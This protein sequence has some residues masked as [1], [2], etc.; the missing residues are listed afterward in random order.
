M[1]NE[2]TLV[3]LA[4]SINKGWP[5]LYMATVEDRELTV[6]LP[7]KTI[8][9]VY[10]KNGKLNIRYI[11]ERTKS[12]R[13]HHLV[14]V[15]LDGELIRSVKTSFLLVLNPYLKVSII[16]NSGSFMSP[17]DNITH[18][19]KLVLDTRLNDVRARFPN[20][21]K[22][23]KLFPIDW[24]Y[25]IM[26]EDTFGYHIGF[27][28]SGSTEIRSSDFTID[29]ISDISELSKVLVHGLCPADSPMSQDNYLAFAELGYIDDCYVDADKGI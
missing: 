11:P 10:V 29:Q 14:S 20:L 5:N 8:R 13:Y 27:Q 26:P 25:L 2:N 4:E 16:E 7:D 15:L 19:S 23:D 12:P 6:E 1:L 9:K 24:D 22:F 3:E 21:D 17:T 18:A 28:L